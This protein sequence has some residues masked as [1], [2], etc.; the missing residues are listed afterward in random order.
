MDY[1]YLK[2]LFDGGAI[3]FEQLVAALGTHK[4]IKLVNL[5]DGGYVAKEKHDNKVKELTTE[6]EG[7]KGQLTEANTT[8]QSYKDM[9]IDG[10]K[11]SATEWQQKYETDTK[12]LKEKLDAQATEFAARTYLSGYQYTDDL[13]KDAIYDKFMAKGFKR[14]EDGKFEG[15]D[16]WMEEMKKSF[17]SSFAA[18]KPAADPAGTPPAGDGT[19]APNSPS[20]TPAG[21][22][23]AGKPRPWFAPPAGPSGSSGGKKMSLSEMM[24]FKNNHPDAKIDFE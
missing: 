3:T 21:A 4:E 1:E 18:S 12:S 7:V 23:P 11:K 9:D 22:P 19:P 8:I 20:G 15:A 24:T 10:I 16:S 2:S 13:V 6:L 17:P 5:A 14:S